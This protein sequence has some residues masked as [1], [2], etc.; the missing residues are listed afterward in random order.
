MWL[1][2]FHS[3]VTAQQ[4]HSQSF[5]SKVQWFV[6]EAF[7]ESGS[8]SPNTA[9]PCW[10]KCTVWGMPLCSCLY[11]CRVLCMEGRHF[12]SCHHYYLTIWD[13]SISQTG[14]FKAALDAL[15]CSFV[16]SD[17]G[18]MIFVLS[19]WEIATMFGFLLTSNIQQPRYVVILAG[20]EIKLKRW[21]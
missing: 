6:E 13:G 8:V 7:A 2:R 19:C 5:C 16:E 4:S 12:L 1:C 10:Y 3:L 17:G 20:R 15:N 9:V 18:Q 21:Y 14:R 11:R